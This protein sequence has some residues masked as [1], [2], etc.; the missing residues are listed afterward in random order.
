LW[1]HKHATQE[2][3]LTVV[4]IEEFRGSFRFFLFVLSTFS[5]FDVKNRFFAKNIFVATNAKMPF[6]Q[7]KKGVTNSHHPHQAFRENFEIKSIWFSGIFLP[8]VYFFHQGGIKKGKNKLF[9]NHKNKQLF[10]RFWWSFSQLKKTLFR[11]TV[12]TKNIFF[13]NISKFQHEMFFFIC[14]S[15]QKKEEHPHEKNLLLTNWTLV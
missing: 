11:P 5:K 1:V 2:S 7:K 10:V 8:W 15:S 4:Y 3:Y 12:Q 14:V 9:E 6:Y 13:G